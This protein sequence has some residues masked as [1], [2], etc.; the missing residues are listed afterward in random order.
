ME[1]PVLYKL[2]KGGPCFV[3]TYKWRSQFYI[4]AKMEVPVLYKLTNGGPCPR[5]RHADLPS[6]LPNVLKKKLF[7]KMRNAYETYMQKLFSDL[8]NKF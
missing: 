1:V 2:T 8:F 4:N 5:E 7:Q 3:Q 6:L